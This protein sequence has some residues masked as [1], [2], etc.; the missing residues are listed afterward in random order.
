M[1]TNLEISGH[2]QTTNSVNIPDFWRKGICERKIYNL[3][4][5]WDFLWTFTINHIKHSVTCLILV[6]HHLHQILDSIK[7]SV[8]S[9]LLESFHYTFIYRFKLWCL[10]KNRSGKGEEYRYRYKRDD[11]NRDKNIFHNK[12]SV[13]I[14]VFWTNQTLCSDITTSEGM[15]RKWGLSGY[16]CISFG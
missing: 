15:K 16:G 14:S 5:I 4:V 10:S 6:F 3:S 2:S 12:T 11:K 9:F 7:T 13:I 8:I 1:S